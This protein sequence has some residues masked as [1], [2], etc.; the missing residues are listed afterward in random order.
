MKTTLKLICM[1]A[2]LLMLTPQPDGATLP[3]TLAATKPLPLFEVRALDG[4]KVKSQQL[5][6]G[7]KWLLVY[8]EP[9]CKPCEEVLRV[10]KRQ[11]PLASIEQKLAV[12]VGGR[13]A[14]EVKSLASRFA[15]I[16]ESCWYADA[17]SASATALKAKGAPVVFGIRSG[18]IEWSLSG[19][20]ANSQ[21]LESILLT[22]VAG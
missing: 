19:V 20:L 9:G 14:E 21:K 15:W 18:R 13:S 7:D 1:M 12:V 22:W 8:V 2:F 5:A 16:P 10:F 11:P 3:S 17:S 4:R 6:G